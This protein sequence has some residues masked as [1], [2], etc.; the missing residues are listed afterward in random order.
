M[1]MPAHTSDR[2][3][4]GR[5]KSDGTLVSP[6]DWRANRLADIVAHRCAA[7]NAVAGG[8]INVIND[9]ASAVM[10]EAAILAACTRAAN[11]YKVQVVTPSGQTTSVTRRDSGGIAPPAGVRAAA[12]ASKLAATPPPPP[13]K[14]RKAGADDGDRSKRCYGTAGNNPVAA[15]ARAHARGC[16]RKRAA[17]SAQQIRDEVVA[18]RIVRDRAA[19]A[20][21]S[22]Q[23][24]AARLAA[25]RARVL[26][27]Q[28]A[29]EGGV[30]PSG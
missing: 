21:P 7:S 30:A 9:A 18:M 14:P 13:P 4:R 6:T 3:Y 23:C 8:I 28:A 27:R 24:P 15:A 11:N 22:S 2:S 29:A 20:A 5:T 25:L 26:A 1:W 19:A 12:R 17:G 10:H 16:K